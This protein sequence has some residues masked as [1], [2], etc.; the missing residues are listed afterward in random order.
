MA[1]AT[2]TQKFDNEQDFP[3]LGLALITNPVADPGSPVEHANNYAEA[4]ASAPK[5]MDLLLKTIREYVLNPL[6]LNR[7]RT[8]YSLR[9]K[10]PYQM[11]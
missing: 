9:K 8:D 3:L 1:W 2:L 7:D 5:Y 4:L 11:Y 6:Y 10:I